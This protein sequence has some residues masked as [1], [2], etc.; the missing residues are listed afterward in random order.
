[1]TGA[2]RRSKQG[3][4]NVAK[5]NEDADNLPFGGKVRLA[6]R[7]KP[8][9]WLVIALEVLGAAVVFVLV[10]LG[11]YHQEAVHFHLNHAYAHV[12]HAHAQHVVA[13]KYLHGNGVP[14]NSSMA[15]YWFRKAADQGHAHSAYNLAVGH[16]QGFATDVKKGEAK[17]LIKYA[18]DNGVHEAH[19]VYHE[20]CHAGNE[21]ELRSIFIRI[22]P[23][24]NI[25]LLACQTPS[26]SAKLL[27]ADP[28]TVPNFQLA[29]HIYQ[30]TPPSTF[31]GV[32]HDITRK[33]SSAVL[34]GNPW[35]PDSG[36]LT[37]RMMC[38]THTALITFSG[39]HIPHWV[40]YQRV[41]V[42]C[43]P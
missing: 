12:G 38:S 13:H 41:M 24:G 10:Y 7:R 37:A 9:G 11:Y 15:F 25:A 22:L 33:T 2:R 17:K 16:M 43:A 26:V 32:T 23:E 29:A 18:A 36:I 39:S 14:K 28:L 1:M 20:A 8:D 35:D 3:K 5:E 21:A 6:R 19:R 27:A 34:M 4:R 31:R 42:R 40:N 30:A